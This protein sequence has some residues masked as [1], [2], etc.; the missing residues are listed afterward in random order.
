MRDANKYDQLTLFGHFALSQGDDVL[1]HFSYDKVKAL[2]VYLLLHR[3]PVN[4]AALA[5]LLW[6]DQG[7]SSGRTNLRHALHC[8]RQSLGED[9]E[10]VLNVSRQTIAFQLPANWQVDLHELQALLEGPRDLETL[11]AV[12]TC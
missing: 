10:Q 9:A 3:Q 12:L 4:R 11:N 5:E 8:L 2:L 1:T 7:L 6:P